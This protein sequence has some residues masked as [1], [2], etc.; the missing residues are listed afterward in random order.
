MSVPNCFGILPWLCQGNSSQTFP[1]FRCLCGQHVAHELWLE[2]ACFKLIM[3]SLL[4]NL[5]EIP[6]DFRWG[7]RQMV[8]RKQVL[9][10]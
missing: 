4:Y 5:V 10:T 1:H 9:Q 7:M 6:L 3:E 2:H 8:E